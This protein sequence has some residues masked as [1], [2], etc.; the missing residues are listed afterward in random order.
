[1]RVCVSCSL[2][3]REFTNNLR[4]STIQMHRHAVARP[5]CCGCPNIMHG[6][7]VPPRIDDPAPPPLRVFC[8]SIV[9]PVLVNAASSLT[10]LHIAKPNKSVQISKHVHTYPCTSG[11]YPHTRL[12]THGHTHK[13]NVHMERRPSNSTERHPARLTRRRTEAVG[14][15]RTSTSITQRP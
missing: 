5:C 11:T 8:P 4:A 6:T 1:M 3:V 2:Q 15:E 9:P 7:R 12:Y 10:L 14:T 13:I